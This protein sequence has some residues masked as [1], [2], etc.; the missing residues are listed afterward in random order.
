MAK[1]LQECPA[2]GLLWS[3]SIRRETVPARQKTR[4]VDALKKCQKDA[5]VMVAAAEVF[6]RDRKTQ[7]ARSWFNRAA[8]ADPDLGDVWVRLYRFE[9][10]LG[11]DE[12]RAAVLKRCA[13]A[14]PRYGELWTA[15]SKAPGSEGMTTE[16]ILKEAAS[17]DSAAVR[18]A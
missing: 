7:K 6:W 4:L 2:S 18:S 8:A 15:V 3:E 14:E 1:A 11:T 17:R 13:D 12:T 16:L 5:H 10:M 9:M